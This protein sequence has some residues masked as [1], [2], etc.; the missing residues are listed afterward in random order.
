MLFKSYKF[1]LGR[2]KGT[3]VDY[4]KSTYGKQITYIYELPNRDRYGCLLPPNQI[5]PTGEE[6]M[7]SL[8]VIFKEVKE[9]KQFFSMYRKL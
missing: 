7:D 5:I 1:L 2:V 6:I 4:I 9:R 8:V 3:S